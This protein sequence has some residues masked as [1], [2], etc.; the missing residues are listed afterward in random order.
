M[1][2]DCAILSGATSFT[3]LFRGDHSYHG[4]SPSG[5]S[6][7]R[8][9][10]P[11]LRCFTRPDIRDTALIRN[12]CPF[13]RA[14]LFLIVEVYYSVIRVPHQGISPRWASSASR[15]MIF[16]G[17]ETHSLVPLSRFVPGITFPGTHFPV[18]AI[19]A[20]RPVQL[21]VTRFATH[22]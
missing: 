19:S 22:P 6:Q 11:R 4:H 20:N 13:R 18:P 3:R 5:L 17:T 2:R 9:T 15:P 10:P 16:H 21:A 12:A 8:W 1:V 7:L 14:S